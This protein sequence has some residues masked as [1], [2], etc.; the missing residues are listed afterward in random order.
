GR[1]A[2]E[3]LRGERVLAELGGDVGV[4]EVGEPAADLRGRQEEVPQP[5]LLGLVLGL[6]QQLELAGRPRPA[7]LAALAQLE[8]L[9]RDRRDVLLDVLH[10]RVVQRLRL[11]RHGEVVQLGL[12]VGARLAGRGLERGGG[13]VHRGASYVSGEEPRRV[14]ASAISAA[15]PTNILSRLLTEASGQR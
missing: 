14:W 10:H 15:L 1:R 2:V 6:L 9:L 12:L 5:R 8:E 4:V 11:L 13:C 3:R 7:L